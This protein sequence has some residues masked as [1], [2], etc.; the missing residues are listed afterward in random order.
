MLHNAFNALAGFHRT[1]RHEN[2]GNIQTH[3]RQEHTGSNL[4]AVRDT[5][6]RIRAV[7]VHHVFDRVGNEVARRQGIEHAVVAHRNAVIDRNGVEF[8]RHAASFT[9]SASH[10]VAHIFQVHVTGHELGVRV[11]NRNNRFAEIIITHAGCA[12]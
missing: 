7:S 2:R 4:V 11:S 8:F 6:E 3:R 5:Y 10:Q 1:A 12:P 9:N